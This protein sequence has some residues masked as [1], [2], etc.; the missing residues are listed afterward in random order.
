[1]VLNLLLL[2]IILLPIRS[3]GQ[4]FRPYRDTVNHFS[5]SIPEGW[6]YGPPPDRS[7]TF[8][9]LRQKANETD[10]PRESVSVNFLFKTETDLFKSYKSFVESLSNAERFE[11]VDQ[12]DRVIH[13]RKYKWLIEIHKNKMGE[14]YLKRY[15]LFTNN[16]GEILTVTMTTTVENFPVY[17][18]LFERVA[19]S[20]A[21]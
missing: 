8:I 11:L 18:L 17:V 19:L 5:I 10:K 3:K 2:A 21:Y 7:V 1:M 14:E 9:A 16:N 13:N 20:L 12:G 15:I 6:K 4:D